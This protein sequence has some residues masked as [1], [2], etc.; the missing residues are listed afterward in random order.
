M[1][2]RQNEIALSSGRW[3]CSDYLSVMTGVCR[4]V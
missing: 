4:R 1:K 2:C 3:P